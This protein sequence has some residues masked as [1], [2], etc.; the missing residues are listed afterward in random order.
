MKLNLLNNMETQNEPNVKARTKTKLDFLLL[1][2]EEGQKIL[3]I[4]ETAVARMHNVI[5]NRYHEWNITILD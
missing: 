5:G 1:M 2:S 3:S 4:L